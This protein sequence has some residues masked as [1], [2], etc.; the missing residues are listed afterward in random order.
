MGKTWEP[1]KNKRSLENGAVIDRKVF[2]FV[3]FFEGLNIY[4]SDSEVTDEYP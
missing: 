4:G 2:S 3:S 1:S